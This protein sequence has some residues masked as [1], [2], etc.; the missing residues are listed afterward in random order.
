MQDQ[1]QHAVSDEQVDC[2]CGPTPAERRTFWPSP[3]R[4]SLVTRRG[5][6]TFGALGVA[7]LGALGAV[8]A[9]RGR[10]LRM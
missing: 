9:A 1:R 3:G 6:L 2:G 7:T 5:A 8:I 10:K 4:S